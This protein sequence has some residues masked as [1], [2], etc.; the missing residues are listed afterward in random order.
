M[1]KIVKEPLFYWSTEHLVIIGIFTAMIKVTTL[2]ISLMGGG[3]NPVSLFIKNGMAT[4]LLVILAVR[5]SRPGVFLL[6]CLVSQI[7]GLMLS[8]GTM[9]FLLP[10]MLISA[11]F[12]D[13]YLFLIR[14]R[15]TVWSILPAI[16]IFDLVGKFLSLAISG[17]MLR[18]NPA[19][20]Y[21]GAFFISLGYL[22]CLC[23]GL[24]L[25]VKLVKELQHAGI[26]RSI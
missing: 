17:L 1:D 14:K 10:G 15:M 18:E 19:M 20:F 24:P 9:F 22:G 11:I 7:V 23:I 8:G 13:S 6:Y 2:I 25:G 3:M 16:F 4:A 26:V 12:A 5:I 21:T